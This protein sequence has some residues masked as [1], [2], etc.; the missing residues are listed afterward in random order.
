MTLAH[1]QNE[2]RGR[3]NLRTIMF[4]IK[5]EFSESFANFSSYLILGC[6]IQ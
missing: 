5:T 3:Q 1:Q 6:Q 4:V 2:P